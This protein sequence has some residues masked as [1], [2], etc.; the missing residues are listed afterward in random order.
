MFL[1]VFANFFT[2]SLKDVV[3]NANIFDGERRFLN[4]LLSLLT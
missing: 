2:M 1:L 4:N 3:E